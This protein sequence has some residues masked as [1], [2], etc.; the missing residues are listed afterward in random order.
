MQQ[1]DFIYD[2]VDFRLKKT[3]PKILDVSSTFF[4]QWS[5]GGLALGIYL[6]YKNRNPDLYTLIVVTYSICK[7]KRIFLKN[8][9]REGN[10]RITWNL[11]N[12][13]KRRPPNHNNY[14]DVR[15]YSDG[16]NYLM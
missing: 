9:F 6:E 13:W 4:E 16:V 10:F 12:I 2:L 15:H 7:R 5:S 1:I 8:I 11:Q 3:I 14:N